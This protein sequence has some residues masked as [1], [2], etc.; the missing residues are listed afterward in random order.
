MAA[1]DPRLNSPRPF[2]IRRFNS[3]YRRWPRLL[4]SYHRRP[5]ESRFLSLFPV[6]FSRRV[7][8]RTSRLQRVPS[9]R[10]KV[11]AH[12][13]VIREYLDEKPS[14]ATSTRGAI[15]TVSSRSFSRV[16]LRRRLRA[17]KFLQKYACEV[18]LVFRSFSSRPARNWNIPWDKYLIRY[19]VAELIGIVWPAREGGPIYSREYKDPSLAVNFFLP[20]QVSRSS[21]V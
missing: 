17:R 9:R 8:R 16:Y 6:L 21:E 1:G 7:S 11:R 14:G 18:E 20:R 15:D 12:V 10:N 3:Q 13:T 5:S 4:A 19:G 2:A